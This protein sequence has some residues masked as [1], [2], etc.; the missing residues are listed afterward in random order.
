[1]LDFNAIKIILQLVLQLVDVVMVLDKIRR[2]VI[3]VGI[4]VVVLVGF[5]QVISVMG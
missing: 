1:M 2:N 3:M 5:S 4:L